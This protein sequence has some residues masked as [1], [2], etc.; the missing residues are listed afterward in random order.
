MRTW[1]WRNVR[2]PWPGPKMVPSPHADR[3]G[4]PVRVV[5]RGSNGN[6]LMVFADGVRVVAPW[7]AALTDRRAA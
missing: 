3:C 4:E 1:R 6:E 5:C 2:N 7:R